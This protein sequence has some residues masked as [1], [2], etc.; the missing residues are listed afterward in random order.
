VALAA[1]YHPMRVT[2]FEKNGGNQLNVYFE[3]VK[4]QKRFI[5]DK[6]LFHKK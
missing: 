5:P 1:G 4:I 3:S 6:L 2:Y